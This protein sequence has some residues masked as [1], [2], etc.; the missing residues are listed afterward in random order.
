MEKTMQN[1][2]LVL[3]KIKSELKN[4]NTSAVKTLTNT[5]HKLLERFLGKKSFIEDNLDF[6][7]KQNDILVDLN[8]DIDKEIE[9]YLIREWYPSAHNL[10]VAGNKIIDSIRSIGLLR[11][12]A[13]ESINKKIISWK[14][15]E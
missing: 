2:D 5:Y 13:I 9:G 1:M 14:E 11:K 3:T 12:E 10:T 7:K 15:N 8:E 4:G 6:F